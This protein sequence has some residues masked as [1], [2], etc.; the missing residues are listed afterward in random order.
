MKEDENETAKALIALKTESSDITKYGVLKTKTEVVK[1]VQLSFKKIVFS[2]LKQIVKHGR[3][4]KYLQDEGTRELINP[5]LHALSA[6]S[7]S[8][9]PW[10]INSSNMVH[11][12]RD[13]V[14]EM[15]TALAKEAAENF[16]CLKLD[17][18]KYQNRYFLG[19]FR[20]DFNTFKLYTLGYVELTKSSTAQNLKE[21]VLKCSET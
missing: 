4:I 20:K 3:P 17:G 19:Q 14:N 11:F 8:N 9:V 18:A 10:V 5:L 12:M 21:E 15:K 2:Q 13:L 6:Q 16:I 1:N 7:K